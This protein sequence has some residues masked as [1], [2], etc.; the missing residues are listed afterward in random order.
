MI[1]Q[2]EA[3]ARVAPGSAALSAVINAA[4]STTL[5]AATPLVGVAIPG[6][7]GT[8]GITGRWMTFIWIPT[9]ADQL[10]RLCWGID[11]TLAAATD[12]AFMAGVEYD[13]WVPRDYTHLS[14]LSAGGG[15]L[16]WHVSNK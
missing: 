3:I 16:S 6:P 11:T 2:S 8:A 9:V 14:G 10:V 1:A 5:V 15:E 12:R 4:R 7:S 13:Y